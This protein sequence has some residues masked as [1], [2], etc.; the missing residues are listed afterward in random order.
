MPAGEETSPEPALLSV[1]PAGFEPAKPA[2]GARPQA[3]TP[4]RVWRQGCRPHTFGPEL[5]HGQGR[6]DR[7]PAPQV[8]PV[9]RREVVERRQS[10]RSSV[11]SRRPWATCRRILE[12]NRMRPPTSSSMRRSFTWGMVT[13][14]GPAA[15]ATVRDRSQLCRWRTWTCRQRATPT[16]SST[17]VS[18]H[19][20]KS[21]AS[22]P[23]GETRV[24]P[25]YVP[26]PET[27]GRQLKAREHRFRTSPHRHPPRATTAGWSSAAVCGC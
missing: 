5:D 1:P 2:S 4:W 3:R 9:L 27:H 12:G 6:L 23:P 20:P 11:S 18:R 17:K 7:V 24:P 10:S 8:G 16:R 13:S 21:R 25:P 22:S 14:T 26:P 19:V 15:V